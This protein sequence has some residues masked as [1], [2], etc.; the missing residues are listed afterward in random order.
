MSVLT[1]IVVTQEQITQ[2]LRRLGIRAGD[3]VLF[4]CSLSSL[5]SVVGGHDALI[6]GVLGAVGRDGT[7][8]MPCL[9]DF[10]RPFHPQTS[11]STVGSVSEVFRLRKEAVRSLHPTHSVAAI[12]GAALYLTEGH[13][14]C[15]PCGMG[16][17]FDKLCQLDGWVLLMG[18]DQDRNTSL[19]MAEDL[20]NAPY[21]RTL[22]VPVLDDQ[23]QV[24][25]VV[26]DKYPCGH[27][28][29]IGI[30][31]RLR[32]MGVV[33]CGHIGNAVLRL[34][35]ARM[36]LESAL[37][38][39]EQDPTVFLCKKP[40]C[41]WCRWAEATVKGSVGDDVAVPDWGQLS[42]RWGCTDV[43]CECCYIM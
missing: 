26:V 41:V 27:R 8:V 25:T 5:G 35:P 42:R 23:G 1:H 11:P 16:S 24:Q 4:H 18:V 3:A 2:A 29:F 43:R 14:A 20:A 12:G 13:A 6:D 31:K 10:S 40:R 28:E 21:L 36:L 9:P 7:A 39:L 37:R 32:E 17:P 22:Q 33:R 38:L 19:H 34:M 15:T 30:D